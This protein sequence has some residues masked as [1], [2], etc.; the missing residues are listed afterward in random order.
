[1][2][3]QWLAMQHRQGCFA[4]DPCVLCPD[5]DGKWRSPTGPTAQYICADMP[6]AV[7]RVQPTPAGARSTKRGVCRKGCLTA[8]M[9]GPTR[10]KDT[11]KS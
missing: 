1:M 7:D 9:L 2:R 10:T 8:C 6:C 11:Q 4:Y 3:M 5:I